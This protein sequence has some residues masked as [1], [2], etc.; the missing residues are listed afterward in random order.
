[1]KATAYFFCSRLHDIVHLFVLAKLA[2][3]V[4][5]HGVKLRR[6]IFIESLPGVDFRE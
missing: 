5:S 3:F 4:F 6:L 2:E 1:M